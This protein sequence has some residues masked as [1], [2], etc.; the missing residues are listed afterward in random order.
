VAD[1]GDEEK[2]EFSTDSLDDVEIN[3]GGN[4]DSSADFA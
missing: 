4:E 3:T 1:N 2:V